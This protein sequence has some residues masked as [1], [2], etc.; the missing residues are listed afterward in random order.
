M[1]KGYDDRMSVLVLLLVLSLA[2]ARI[3]RLVVED[4]ITGPM[5]V[6]F[7]R[8]FGSG[9]RLTYLV[10]C[11]WCTGMWVSA[12]LCVFAAT[13]GLVGWPSAL[14]LI[15]ASAYASN[16]IRSMIEE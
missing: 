5:R 13:V 1:V 16:I 3:T 7:V 4:E 14:L 8:R 9:S 12:G 2:G 6:W 15:P 10:H 11:R